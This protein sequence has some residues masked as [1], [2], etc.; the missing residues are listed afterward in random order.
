MMDDLHVFS[1]GRNLDFY[2]LES[3]SALI[4]RAIGR[5]NRACQ[6]STSGRALR[7]LQQLL[8]CQPAEV[9]RLHLRWCSRSRRASCSAFHGGQETSSA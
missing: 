1:G 7:H 3:L 2:A 4:S 9:D 5:Q 6:V 8:L